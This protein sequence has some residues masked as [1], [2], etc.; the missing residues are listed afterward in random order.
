VEKLRRVLGPDKPHTLIAE[1][2]LAAAILN[3]GRDAEGDPLFLSSLQ[4][5]GD[6]FGEDH[7]H[8]ITMVRTRAAIYKKRG[9]YSN[10]KEW[11]E[12]ALRLAE[13]TAPG[14]KHPLFV[15]CSYDLAGVAARLGD[16][17]QALTL[18][19]VPSAKSM[20]A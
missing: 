1:N 4:G 7:L 11:L 9:A 17:E 6:I 19:A 20:I 8:H 10:A 2:N 13:K 16:R 3:Q 18:S 5:V 14:G 15:P 12:R